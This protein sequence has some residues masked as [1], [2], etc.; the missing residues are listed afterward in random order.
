LTDLKEVA[1]KQF[2]NTP[3]QEK[4]G[5]FVVDPSIGTVFLALKLFKENKDNL[6]IYC[7]NNFEVTDVF[8]ALS[9]FIEKHDLITIPSDELLRVEYLSE[10]KVLLSQQIFGLY[11]LLN[12]KH[13]I[14]ILS[15][16]S[17]Y[18]F[19]PS[20]EVF[21][22]SCLTLKVGETYDFNSLKDQ[23]TNIS[24]SRVQK[25]DQS[26][27][28]AVRG[29]IIDV[30]SLNYD[31]PIRI[32]FFDNEIES[33]RFFSI[34]TQTSFEEIKEITILPASL[35]LLK[36]EEKKMGCEKIR[37]K[38]EE[39]KLLLSEETFDELKNQ[40][41]QDI[42]D[43]KN[44][45]V[46][47]KLYK[48]FGILNKE[49]NELLDYLNDNYN[50]ILNNEEQFYTARENLFSDSEVFLKEL[51]R[52]GRSIGDLIYFNKSVDV[53]QNCKHRYNL[54]TFFFHSDSIPI[55]LNANFLANAKRVDLSILFQT[56]I[57]NGY[58]VL[59]LLE[60]KEQV[61]KIK[62]ILEIINFSYSLSSNLLIDETKNVTLSINS[63]P[64]ALEIKQDKIVVL[65][66]KEL[67]GFRR[68]ASTYSSKFKEGI[69]LGSYQDLEPGD[70]V[71][72]ERYGIG[73]FI[74]ITTLELNDKHSDYIQV[75]YADT[76]VLYV[77]LY[78]FSLIRKYIGKDGYTPKLNSLHGNKWEKTK[79]KIK[80]RINNLA[81]RL[82]DL[83][84]K[85]A[86]I[87]GMSYKGDEELEEAFARD[88]GYELTKDQQKSLGE[89]YRD[90]E[91]ESPMDRLLCGDVG[92][93]KTE[94]AFRAAFRVILS[95]KMVIIFCPTTLL[96]RQ[97]YDVALKRFNNFKVNIALYTR[98]SSTQDVKR[99]E[100]EIKEGK[101]DLLIG[102]HKVLSNKI[103]LTNLGLL[104]IDEEQRFGVE[105]KEKIKEKC[106]NID[107]LTLSA[108]PI[109]RTLQ[110]SLIGLKQV[111]TITTPPK[112]RL[113]I[114][115]YVIP[116]NENV[117]RE[118]IKRELSRHG[119]IFYVHND[120]FSIYSTCETLQKLVPECKI[121]I[122][123]GRMDK[124][125]INNSM[126]DFYNGQ[127][128]LLLATSII[129]NGIDVENANLILIENANSFGLTQLYQI[130]GRVGRGD[131]ISFA[132]LM[133]N[134]EKKINEDGQKR[135]EAIQSFT[136]LGS[137]YK[138]AQRDL[139]I[140]GAGDILGPEQA[141][142]IDVVG[143]DMYIK[144][145]NETIEEKKTGIKK[146]EEIK[147]HKDLGIDAY[148]PSK[149][150]SDNEK[151]DI[152]Q[153]ILHCKN[154]EELNEN[155]KTIRDIYG[156]IPE[157]MELLYLKRKL[158]MY[159]D[160]EEFKDLDE[161][162]SCVNLIL[163]SNFSDI[164][165]IGTSLFTALAPYLKEVTVSF[166]NK[167]LVIT[168]K[169]RN[170]WVD[171]L[172]TICAIV[173]NLYKITLRTKNTNEN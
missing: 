124:E 72:H 88:F 46:T 38:L 147:I 27:Q 145:L 164:E 155:K 71:V 61:Y 3:T 74:Q 163:N 67:F 25:I 133:I 91:K 18:K 87:K 152:Y 172:L 21:L 69:I 137:G 157:S 150:I 8:N 95:K 105:Q 78:Q 23:L 151:V 162:Q 43:I 75:Q 171:L 83:Y 135:L 128:D 36:N 60:N 170:D 169:K 37:E 64:K 153:N 13:K 109:P 132:Y 32:E 154:F 70:Y 106:K 33:I 6:L 140:R 134:S 149:Y 86:Q 7:S 52:E 44:N 158:D 24:Y 82:M 16:S 159:L 90:L 22:S 144:L 59:C 99:I 54:N 12:A 168:I 14:I 118:L 41:E 53:F 146:A 114:Q 156:P 148:I 79:Q 123:H 34:G 92:F 68:H 161:H 115:T 97:H 81:E 1:I 89:I 73:K 15:P 62:S 142:F 173:D 29:D 48:Y 110:S 108:T 120:I 141:G 131:R 84:S 63:F 77:P 17:L 136:A 66:S 49:P 50:I 166:V 76:D 94:I 160:F 56:Y 167:E 100:N 19:Y 112:E 35:M 98:M 138:I 4:V 51:N 139:L 96:A 116:Y 101:I 130:K 57:K 26:L 122:V 143:V 121:G 93:G 103:D 113:A 107:V 125:D 85:R 45:N 5:N 65:T 55:D 102:T 127:I 126:Q 2:D 129:E 30:F 10:S 9:T 111:S 42:E 47:S 31:N 119:Q 28:F 11:S 117:I 40:T 104:V 20:K 80:E 58:K 165:G 39:E